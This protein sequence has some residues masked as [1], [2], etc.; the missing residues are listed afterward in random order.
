MGEPI[1]LWRADYDVAPFMRWACDLVFDPSVPDFFRIT[2][3]D[4][5]VA[6]AGFIGRVAYAMAEPHLAPAD[7]GEVPPGQIVDRFA[8]VQPGSVDHFEAAVRAIPDTRVRSG[9]AS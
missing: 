7:P 6:D 5:R 3:S 8:V 2:K 1:H 4:P 9:G